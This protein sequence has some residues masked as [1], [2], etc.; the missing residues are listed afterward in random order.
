M[1]CA[2][3]VAWVVPLAAAA[4]ALGN[5][6]CVGAWLAGCAR[7]AFVVGLDRYVPPAFGRIHPRWGTPYVAIL[8]QAALS[9]I[10]LFVSVLGKGTTVEKAY[11]VLLDTMILV[12]FIPY[13]YMFL[14][15]LVFGVGRR[16]ESQAVGGSLRRARTLVVG[17][18]GLAVTLFAMVV[19][20][21]PPPGTTEPW[22]FELK[23]VGGSAAFVATGGLLY[24]RAARVA[25]R[26]LT[27]IAA[28]AGQEA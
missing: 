2:R 10:F 8:V 11:L 4:N 27:G 25:A 16:T 7:V 13:C 24:W 5:L 19:A 6:G 28:R 21:I 20:T 18:T 17:C 23:V 15:F 22:L 26:N 1:V 12:Y 9:T 14:T 3:I